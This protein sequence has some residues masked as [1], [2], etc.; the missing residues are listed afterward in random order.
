MHM[1]VFLCALKVR[2]AKPVVNTRGIQTPAHVQL[3]LKKLQVSHDYHFNMNINIYIANKIQFRCALLQ[4]HLW[5]D[6][7]IQTQGNILNTNNFM[8]L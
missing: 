4:L 5:R 8:V 6:F 3:K 1:S 7:V 2:A